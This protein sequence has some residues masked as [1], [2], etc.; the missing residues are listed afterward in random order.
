MQDQYTPAALLQPLRRQLGPVAYRN[1]LLLVLAVQLGR[2]FLVWQLSLFVLVPISSASCYRRLERFLSWPGWND[3]ARLD[4]WRSTWVRLVLRAFAPT[5]SRLVL[6]I[7]WTLHRDRCASLWVMLPVGGRAVPLCFFLTPLAFGGLGAQRQFEDAC[8]R[9]LARWLPRRRVV[10]V[11]DRGFRGADR[12]RFLKEALGWDFVLRITAET[13]I[14]AP[15]ERDWLLLAHLAPASG[16]RWE[17][18]G[19]VLGRTTRQHAP[20]GKKGQRLRVVA[21]LVAVRQPLLAPKPGK[22]AHGKRPGAGAPESTWFLATSLPLGPGAADSVELYQRR[23]QIEQTFRDFKSFFGMEQEKTR[24]PWERLHALLWAVT[25]GQ[26][27]ALLACPVPPQATPPQRVRPEAEPTARERRRYPRE[28][29]TRTGLH[30]WL[31]PL[32]AERG[33]LGEPLREMAQIAARMQA[34]PQVAGRRRAQPA[35][36]NRSRTRHVSS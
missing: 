22:S 25:L 3:P 19:V 27:L 4:R 8:L 33:P 14:Q 34:R 24:K 16:G 26:T 18:A 1:L 21:N 28:S 9:Q 13:M 23:M 2:T 7:D 35:L 31:V 11:G 29:A 5:R 15:G 12:M 20:G 10:L 17:H 30:Q 36:R 6:L 32:L